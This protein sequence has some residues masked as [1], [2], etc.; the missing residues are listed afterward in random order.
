MS[1]ASVNSLLQRARTRLDTIAP[2]S[3]EISEPE[4][5]DRRALLDRYAEA[6]ESADVDALTRLF[7]EDAI[8]EMPPRL[9]WFTGHAALARF[10]AYRFGRRS[11]PIRVVRVSA[12]GQPGFAA[13][14]QLDNDTYE[15]L[16]VQILTISG[17]HITHAIAFTDDKRLVESFGLPLTATAAQIDQLNEVARRQP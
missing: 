17:T 5:P 3:D 7:T 4:D 10:F 14:A 6:F 1:A 8:I 9:E 12:N 16:N 2:A 13:Y 11:S 15:A